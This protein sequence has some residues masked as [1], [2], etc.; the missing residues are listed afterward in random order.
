MCGEW[1]RLQSRLRAY[2]L[3]AFAIV[4]L[5][6]AIV[7][8]PSARQSSKQHSIRRGSA[9]GLFIGVVWGSVVAHL[10]DEGSPPEWMFL[11]VYALGFAITGIAVGAV[12]RC[13]ELVGLAVGCLTVVVLVQVGV[14]HEDGLLCG[15]Q[16][17]NV[18]RDLLAALAPEVDWRHCWPMVFGVGGSLGGILIGGAHRL[19]CPAVKSEQDAPRYEGRIPLYHSH[20]RELPAQGGTAS[21]GASRQ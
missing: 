6:L 21:A 3:S 16:Y 5:G 1:Y 17:E 9:I 14:G 10:N 12:G 4:A 2:T 7:L 15:F 20:R 13:Q 11:T 18:T 8:W 19:V